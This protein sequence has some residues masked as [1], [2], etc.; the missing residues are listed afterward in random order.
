MSD[1]PPEVLY[2]VD[3]RVA[4]LTINR[5][6]ARN[7]LNKAVRDGLREGIDAGEPECLIGRERCS[8]GV[9][10]HQFR[11]PLDPLQA[12]GHFFYVSEED[13]APWDPAPAASRR[14]APAAA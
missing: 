4:W 2:E 10:G 1:I 9:S 6:E 8:R 7:A 13:E 14:A 3:D 5:P 12:R 11:R